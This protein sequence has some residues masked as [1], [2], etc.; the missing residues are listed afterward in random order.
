MD[1]ILPVI[2]IIIVAMLAP[3]NRTCAKQT[4]AS[5]CSP[6]RTFVLSS[7]PR[8]ASAILRKS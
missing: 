6:R 1:S 3:R 2:L 4:L 5:L 8:L 7:A